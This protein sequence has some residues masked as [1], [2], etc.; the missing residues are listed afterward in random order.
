MMICGASVSNAGTNN[1]CSLHD[2]DCDSQHRGL[3]CFESLNQMY[4]CHLVKL[5]AKAPHV[6]FSVRLSEGLGILLPFLLPTGCQVRD[7]GHGWAGR[8]G[9][10]SHL[11]LVE[12]TL[13]V[14]SDTRALLQCLYP[15]L[16]SELLCSAELSR[17]GCC[18]LV[19]RM[20]TRF[21]SACWCHRELLPP[22]AAAT[23][24]V[25]SVQVAIAAQRY[26]HG[27]SGFCLERRCCS[28]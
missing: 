22:G 13:H 7:M 27:C 15:Q 4:R 28:Q 10:S 11:I 14:R 23:R 8:C 18:R 25:L 6:G 5:T 3:I 17:Y 16:E 2:P 12:A 9:D 26:C 20:C 21:E 19:C 1:R 24:A